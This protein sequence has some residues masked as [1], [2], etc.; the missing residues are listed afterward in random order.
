M[1]HRGSV[2]LR[3]FQ[4]DHEVVGRHH[5]EDESIDKTVTK[6]DNKNNEVLKCLNELHILYI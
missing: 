5:E 3:S 2:S 1:Q 6:T 4:N